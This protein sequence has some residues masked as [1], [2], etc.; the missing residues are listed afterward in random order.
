MPE[1]LRF[2]ISKLNAFD[3]RKAA[4]YMALY[5][6]CA[7]S[8]KLSFDV[9]DYNKKQIPIEYNVTYRN[10]KGII[11][12]NADKSPRFGLDHV[13]NI[14]LAPK[15][16]QPEAKCKFLTDIWHPNVRYAGPTKGRVCYNSRDLPADYQLDELVEFIGKMIQY[17]NYHAIL[18]KPP[19]PED[20]EVAKWVVEYAEPL[21]LVDYSRSK[22]VDDA[23][24]LDPIPGNEPPPKPDI[25][26]DY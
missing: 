3:R 1:P 7:Q 26:F 20:P 14:W 10:V 4:D 18:D 11:G 16:P 19:Y 24:L 17:K 13:L 12:I 6:L 2:N 21:G 23:Y 25:E 22:A 15:Y 9:V 8:R 5:K